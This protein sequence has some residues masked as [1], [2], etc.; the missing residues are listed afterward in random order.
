[1]E[2]AVTGKGLPNERGADYPAVLTHQAAVGLIGEKRLT[3]AGEGQRI[4]QAQQQREKQ[5]EH[6]C[7]A[8]G[9]AKIG[10]HGEDPQ[11]RW[12]ADTARS[13]SLIP[14]KG[15]IRPPRP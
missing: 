12:R 15:A 2:I 13:I 9:G 5:G 1:M 8:Q 7:G 4:G 3:D 10:K 14:M 6:E 11:A